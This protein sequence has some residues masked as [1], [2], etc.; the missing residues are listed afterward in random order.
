[1][2]FRKCRALLIAVLIISPALLQ[3]QEKGALDAF[4]AEASRTV[5]EGD[6]EG[7]GATYHEDA[8]MVNALNGKSYSILQALDGWKKGFDDTSSGKMKAGVDFRFSQRL[9]DEATAHD[10]G[11]FRYWYQYKED[12]EPTVALVHFEALLVN[13]EGWKMVMEYQK[14]RATD[15]EW[16]AL[17]GKK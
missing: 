14:S 7:Y 17:G 2:M 9:S 11:I 16:E 6:F 15:E 5:G 10:T 8:V 13:K 4:W 1:M 12:A 3:A